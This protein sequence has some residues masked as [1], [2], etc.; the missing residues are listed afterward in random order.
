MRADEVESTQDTLFLIIA[1]SGAFGTFSPDDD[2]ECEYE[3]S[4]G[5]E[6][7]E[8]ECGEGCDED[9]GQTYT[10]I[11]LTQYL[12]G[13]VFGGALAAVSALI[14][15]G[16]LSDATGGMFEDFGD[17]EG[18]EFFLVG[19]YVASDHLL[20][21]SDSEDGPLVPD[22]TQ[23]AMIPGLMSMGD[24][25][26]ALAGLGG[27]ATV[28]D[29]AFWTQMG[30]TPEQVNEL[31][32]A[33]VLASSSAAGAGENVFGF[34]DAVFLGIGGFTVGP[35]G[36]LIGSWAPVPEPATCLLLAV[37]VA[38]IAWRRRRSRRAA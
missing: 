17:L 29:V 15:A 10:I 16:A 33:G 18:L 31:L 34:T 14:S 25:D 11:N 2:E 22:G 38:G 36:G 23:M 9:G 13:Q 12:P 19:S 7:C 1:N 32:A 35:D 8:D 4:C 21:G 26:P 20:Y 24:L 27:I 37:G 3:E 30:L 5:E 6:E 28:S